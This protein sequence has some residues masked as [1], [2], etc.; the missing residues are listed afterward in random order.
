M[1]SFPSLKERFSLYLENNT[2][3]TVL[4]LVHK[5]VV[6]AVGKTEFEGLLYPY[7]CNFAWVFPSLHS[8]IYLWVL[9][10][11]LLFVGFCDDHV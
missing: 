5:H 7:L 2:Y 10:K 3:E 1:V 4:C 8:R 11:I 6:S 9:I